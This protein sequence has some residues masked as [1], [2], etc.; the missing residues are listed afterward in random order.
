MLLKPLSI[1]FNKVAPEKMTYLGTV[2]DNK[3]PECLGRVKVRISLYTDFMTDQLPWACPILGSCGNSSDNG[4]L[5]V[6]EIGSQVRVEFPSR[7]LT[8]PYYRGAEL[9]KRN[10]VTLFDEDYP[11]TYGYKD[12]NGNFYKVNKVQGTADFRHESSSN[13]HITPDGS[14]QVTLRG[15]VSFI[16][17]SYGSFNLDTGSLEINNKPDGSLEVKSESDVYIQALKTTINGDVVVAGDFV[18]KNGYSGFIWAW[19]GCFEVKDGLIVSVLN[20]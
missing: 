17:S 3:D 13:M 19:N 15:G 4:G 14:I 5:N 8:A 7:D 6:P 11:N 2:E 9:N 20:K 18:A 12:A 1:L 16:L 10:R